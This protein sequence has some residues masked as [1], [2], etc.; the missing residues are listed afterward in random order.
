MRAPPSPPCS[1]IASQ[2]AR[3]AVRGGRAAHAEHDDARA[4]VD[5]GADELA[6]PVRGG[7]PGVALR[8]GHEA[9]P[10]GRGHL[11]DRR[12]PVLDQRELR[13]ERATERVVH[14]GGHQL[15]AQA[16]QQRVE[17]PLAAVGHRAEVGRHQAGALEA[18][19]DQ[20]RHLGGAERALE[21]IRRD[22]HRALGHGGHPGIVARAGVRATIERV[23]GVRTR[24]RPRRAAW[25]TAS[26]VD[27][28]IDPAGGGPQWVPDDSSLLALQGALGVV[29]AKW[30]LSVLT[31][32]HDG[33]Q[34]F[35]EL[36]RQIDGVSRRML[37][38]TLRQLERDGLVLRHVYARV[39]ARVEYELSDS[40]EA[41]L[42][43][44]TPLLDWGKLHQEE[45][46]AARERFDRLQLWR[47]A[48]QEL[49]AQSRTHEKRV[50]GVLAVLEPHRELAE[51]QLVAR[52][53]LRLHDAAA[54]HPGAVERALVAHEP[55]AVADVQHGVV[56]GDRVVG[57]DELAAR[58]AAQLDGGAREPGGVGQRQGGRR[59]A[60][61][62]AAPRAQPPA[63]PGRGLEVGREAAQ[64][65][66]GCG[67]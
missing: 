18:A 23:L 39:P 2:R 57:E 17:R 38:A 5:R 9:E 15:A 8:L 6:R 55:G 49:E 28:P 60:V 22:E 26:A 56:A 47:T 29:G 31:S 30:S 63:P 61:G 58:A 46:A 27:T 59:L 40:G 45:I 11:E 7:R 4:R 51:P 24:I 65:V 36:L 13:G 34:R 32:L 62:G 16:G 67:R 42:L 52:P 66:R 20:R 37:S 3:A 33:T 1:S 10:G 41:L 14:V 19:A 44:L 50:P 54:V 64:L 21:G 12:R 35:N 48:A 25:H 43:A 53:H